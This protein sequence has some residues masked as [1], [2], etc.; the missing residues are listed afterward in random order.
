MILLVFTGKGTFAETETAYKAV[1]TDWPLSSMTA[2]ASSSPASM[3]THK[4]L[5]AVNQME[6]LNSTGMM[7]IYVDYCNHC[8]YS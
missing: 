4:K 2:A 7:G 6:F 8:K 5:L 1:L 3:Q